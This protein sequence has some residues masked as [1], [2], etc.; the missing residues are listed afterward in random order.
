MT[1]FL[2]Y[3]FVYIM[4][5]FDA[6]ALVFEGIFF[7]VFYVVKFVACEFP[8]ISEAI[9][10]NQRGICG[11]TPKWTWTPVPIDPNWWKTDA[12]E[13]MYALETTCLQFDTGWEEFIVMFKLIFN[14]LVCPVLMHARPVESLHTFLDYTIGWMIFRQGEFTNTFGHYGADRS[15]QIAEL[16]ELYGQQCKRPPDAM[17]CFIMGVG[18]MVGRLSLIH[19]RFYRV[20]PNAFCCLDTG[21]PGAPY[22]R[23]QTAVVPHQ[24]KCALA[25]AWLAPI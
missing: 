21:N 14:D 2:T 25:L 24:S 22:D 1:G 13:K 15:R 16:D 11:K 20:C 23:H 12:W 7:A 9:G 10:P 18:F 6:V 8:L 3:I 17:F 4:A 19:A 5:G